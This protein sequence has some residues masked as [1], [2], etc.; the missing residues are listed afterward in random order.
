MAAR[1]LA[2][3]HRERP[4]LFALP[5]E[6]ILEDDHGVGLA[7]PFADE[8]GTRLEVGD[9][10]PGDI[11][12]AFQGLRQINEAAFGRR[13]EAAI[14]LFLDLPGDAE[15]EQITRHPL[16]WMSAIE[17]APLAAQGG[18]IHLFE[19]PQPGGN[20]VGFA[21]VAVADPSAESFSA[22]AIRGCCG[23]GPVLRFRPRSMHGL[24][25]PEAPDGAPSGPGGGRRSCPRPMTVPLCCGP[26]SSGKN[27]KGSVLA[28]NGGGRKYVKSKTYLNKYRE[29]E[30]PPLRHRPSH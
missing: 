14:S 13:A 23:H 9:P 25:P 10:V 3:D 1:N 18:V 19:C 17:P 8:P 20:G 12:V 16:G 26:K 21:V 7:A 24:P 11:T 4:P 15:H 30:S 28:V 27:A 6:A 5:F 29:F 22:A 2:R